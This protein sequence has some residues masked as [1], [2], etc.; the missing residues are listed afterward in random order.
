MRKLD[1]EESIFESEARHMWLKNK[2]GQKTR[3]EKWRH[4]RNSVE[5]AWMN[6]KADLKWSRRHMVV[7]KILTTKKT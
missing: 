2:N 3:L 5:I 1:N 7:P 6:E 4:E